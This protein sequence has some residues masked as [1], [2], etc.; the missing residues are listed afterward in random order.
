MDHD[1]AQQWQRR[2]EAVPDPLGQALTGGI[3]QA[4]DFV[5]IVVIQFGKDWGKCRFDVGKIHD[6]AGLCVRRARNMDFH[7]EGMAV[8][9]STLVPGRHVRKAVRRL[10]LETLEDTDAGVCLCATVAAA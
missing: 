1:L 5:E 6:P 4:G 3:I 7:A 8:Q 9:A 10:D 2:L